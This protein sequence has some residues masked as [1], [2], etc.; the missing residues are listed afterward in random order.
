VL[1]LSGTIFR[2]GSDDALAAPEEKPGWTRFTHDVRMDSTEMTQS[3]FASLLG[4]N[5]SVLKGDRLP[6]TNISWFDAIL[7]ANARSIR[8][9]LDTVY[10]YIAVQADSIGNVGGLTGLTIHLDRAGWRLPTEAEWE[11]AARAGTSTPWAWGNLADSN[12]ADTYAWY[13]KNAQGRPHEVATKSPNAWGLYDMTG[14]VME[15]VGDWKGRFPKDTVPDF[16]GQDVPGDVAEIPLKGG[17]FPYGISSL[18]PSNRTATYAAYRSSRAEYVGFRLARGGFAARFASSSG[19]VVSAPP[20]TLVR[21]DVASLLGAWNARLVF[22]NRASGKSILSWIDYGEQSPVVRTLPDQDPV[23][24]PVI[25][26]DGQW[27]AWCTALEGSTGPSKVKARR[28][29]KNDTVVKDL[30]SGA[31]PRWWTDGADTFLIRSDALDNTDPIWSATKT[32]AQRWSKGALTGSVETWVA[33]GSFHDGRTGP[34]L[35]TGYRR[36]KQ[37]DTRSG[38]GRVLFT[39][40]QDG[41]GGAD[42]S[43]VCNVSA[44]PDATGRSLFLDFGFTG[45]STLVGRPYGIH[46]IAFMADSAGKVVRQIPSPAS[47]RQWEHL[48][49]SNSA[50]WAVSGSIDGTGAYR[51]LYLVDLDSTRSTKIV[52]GQELW[53]PGLWIGEPIRGN[54]APGYNDLQSDSLFRYGY[55]SNAPSNIE[56]EIRLA[57]FWNAHED[58]EA[59]ALGSSHVANGILPASIRSAVTLNLGFAG[60]HL[61]DE[62]EILT[63]YVLPHAPRLKVVILSLMPGWMYQEGIQTS[64]DDT[65]LSVGCEHDRRHGNWTAGLPTGWKAQAKS[66]LLSFGIEGVSDSLGGYLQRDSAAGWGSASPAMLD[67]TGGRSETDPVLRHSMDSLQSLASMLS[68][69][70]IQTILVAFPQSPGYRNTPLSGR[71]GPTWSAYRSIKAEIQ[72]WQIPG[73]HF[74]DAYLDGQHDYTDAEAQNWDHLSFAGATKFSHRLDSLIASLKVATP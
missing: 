54:N 1:H 16:A 19:A 2:L 71:Y 13:Q 42:T 65:R 64:W 3:E 57:S 38:T 27:V 39:P 17:A 20:V 45:T 66:V 23:F 33:S 21:T 74:Y 73:F 67:E 48:E 70:G 58:V 47:E 25:S 55:P 9:K 46:E 7:A 4:R 32:S 53:Q 43:Q 50:R 18:R 34:Y 31:I 5:P 44:S 52:S 8:D 72:N 62:T 11:A 37:Y 68:A 22:L 15:W 26:P 12:K 59:V 40:Q 49:W 24:H 35:Y 6:V 29:L 60:S 56:L 36:L 28:L 14:N 51:N 41:K 10:D 69:R 30:G 63:N 61:H